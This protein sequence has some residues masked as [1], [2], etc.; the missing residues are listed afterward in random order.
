MSD[1][2]ALQSAFLTR[3]LTSGILFSTVLRAVVV[4]KLV[5]VCILFSMFSI[6]ASKSVF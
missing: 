5:I 3:V 2:F 4:A 6:L 1:I